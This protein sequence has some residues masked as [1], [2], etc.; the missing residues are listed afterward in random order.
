MLEGCPSYRL[1]LSADLGPRM[2]LFGFSENIVIDV[3]SLKS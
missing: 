2:G 1:R 3:L